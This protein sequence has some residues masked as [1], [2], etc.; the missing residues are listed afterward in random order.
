MKILI[1]K[2]RKPAR[3]FTLVEVLV[4][5]ALLSI[6][7]VGLLVALSGAS[8]VLLA[9][10]IRESARDLAQAQMENIQ[11]Q[12]YNTADPTGDIE[13][14]AKMAD[15]ASRYPGYE[16]QILAER[17]DK[18]LGTVVDTGLQKVTV[19]VLKDAEPD[20]IFTLDGMKVE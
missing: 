1:K 4:A 10:N 13:F 2:F 5:V 8:K 16:V 18:G 7:G 6:V 3:G 12:T 11:H 15:L 17:I 14:Y 9:A 20:P 19:Q